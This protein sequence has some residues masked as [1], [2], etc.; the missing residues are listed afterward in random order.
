MNDA[1][2]AGERTSISLLAGREVSSVS[3][4]DALALFLSA[5]PEHDMTAVSSSRR[6]RV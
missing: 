2:S 1:L 5:D 6:K 3:F 4:T